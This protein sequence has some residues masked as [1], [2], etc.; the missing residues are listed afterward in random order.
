MNT[1]N[2]FKTKAFTSFSI[3]WTFLLSSLAGLILYI[4]PKGR[5]ANWNLWTLLGMD[6]EQWTAIHT[7]MSFLFLTLAIFHLFVFNWPVFMAYLKDKKSSGVKMKKELIASLAMVFAITFGTYLQWPPFQTVMDL[8]EKMDVYWEGKSEAPPI[9]HAEDLTISQ[10]AEE[11][12]NTGAGKV[13]RTLEEMGI[14]A[15]EEDVLGSLAE[16]QQ[17]SPS[18][19]Y[20]QIYEKMQTELETASKKGYG[21]M[22]LTAVC[23]DMDIS[24]LEAVAFLQ[25][26]GISLSSD[27]QKLYDIAKAN[28]L[29]ATQVA[30]ML[31]DKFGVDV[32]HS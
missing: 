26:Q 17:M 20:N 18:D 14:T 23:L 30:R 27:K 10:L 13:L 5:I 22:S 2:K 29:Q 6:K 16:Q 19:L 7:L 21:Q 25:G 31:I 4:S 1:P 8:G 3:T 15:T 12:L 28:E 24:V 32:E 9:S 11:I